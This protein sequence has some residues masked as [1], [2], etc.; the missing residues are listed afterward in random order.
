MLEVHEGV[1]DQEMSQP[2]VL[3]PCTG[4]GHPLAQVHL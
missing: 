2:H 3:T 4:C 1:S